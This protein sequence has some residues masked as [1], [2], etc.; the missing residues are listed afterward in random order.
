L[1]VLLRGSPRWWSI[2]GPPPWGPSAVVRCRSS[3]VGPLGGGPSSVLLLEGGPSSVP[4]SGGRF[5]RRCPNSRAHAP[6]RSVV[7]GPPRAASLSSA[8]GLLSGASSEVSSSVGAVLTKA[9]RVH[10][11]PSPSPGTESE[12]CRGWP[13]SL[14]SPGSVSVRGDPRSWSLPRDESQVDLPRPRLTSSG[15]GAC[16]LG[17][18]PLPVGKSLQT[19]TFPSQPAPRKLRSSRGALRRAKRHFVLRAQVTG[20]RVP[21]RTCRPFLSP[22]SG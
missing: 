2:V 15:S 12:S 6:I 16:E 18:S 10:R 3:S 19:T 5:S 7:R 20:S 9:F 21:G 13:V 4:P 1:P 22:I 11:D 17:R 8:V 14:P